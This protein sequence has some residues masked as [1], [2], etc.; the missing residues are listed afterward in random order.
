MAC[1]KLPLAQKQLIDEVI[2]TYNSIGEDFDATRRTMWPEFV[3]LKEKISA[4]FQ[5]TNN[6]EQTR[7]AENSNNKNSKIQESKILMR[8]LDSGCGNGRLAHYLSDLPLDY[9][10]FD[11]SKTLI[12]Q[13]KKWWGKTEDS[14]LTAHFSVGNILSKKF[15]KPFDVI[16][17]SAVI[18]HLPTPALQLS[19]LKH[20]NS[21]L[22]DD[23]FLYVTAW[24]LWQP[25]YEDLIDPKTHGSQIAWGK[26]GHTRF[27]Y[28]F[29]K[30]ELIALLGQA[31]FT[32]LE[33]IPSTHNFSFIAWK[34]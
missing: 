33:E 32:T 17:S 26:T 21:L 20:Q 29:T 8:I 5:N 7:N 9:Y 22:A 3:A 10:A 12:A 11:G 14:Q 28:A 13:A 24:N 30:S 6:K 31:G 4:K 2:A 18:H 19:Y 16:I 27:Y 25:K 23:G 15:T 1:V 34:K